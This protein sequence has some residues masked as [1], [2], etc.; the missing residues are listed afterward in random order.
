MYSSRAFPDCPRTVPAV[1]AH[2]CDGALDSA[3]VAGAHLYTSV[4]GPLGTW[5]SMASV[6]PALQRVPSSGATMEADTQLATVILALRSR[7]VSSCQCDRQHD[8]YGRVY[9]REFV[10]S[11]APRARGLPARGH[12][13]PPL[14]CQSDHQGLGVLATMESMPKP[15]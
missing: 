2:F 8:R 10:V 1:C 9:L 5:R 13:Y 15:Q 3:M 12:Q 11:A 6:L 14:L 7:W 4:S